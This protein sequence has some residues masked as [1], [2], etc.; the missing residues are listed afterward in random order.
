MTAPEDEYAVKALAT[1]R[2][3]ESLKGAETAIR[4]PTLAAVPC[5][6]RD[7]VASLSCCCVMSSG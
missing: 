1:Q 4:A 5:P 2:S 3:Y 7:P 6:A